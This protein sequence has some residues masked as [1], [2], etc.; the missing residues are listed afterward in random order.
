MS[1]AGVGRATWVRQVQGRLLGT[2]WGRFGCAALGFGLLGLAMAQPAAL[3]ARKVTLTVRP[4]PLSVANPTLDRVGGLR[5]RGGLWIESEDPGFGGLSGLI[6]N[7]G[8]SGPAMLAV[9]DQGSRF[10]ARLVTANGHLQGVEDAA[11]EPLTELGGRPLVGKSYSDAESL[12]RLPDGRILVGFERRHRIWAYGL[13]LTGPAHPLE[14]PHLLAEAPSNGGLESVTSWPDGRV[15]AITESLRLASGN[16]A[17]FLLQGGVWANLEWK[18]SGEGFLPVDASVLPD[19]DL[20]VLERYF[21]ALPPTKVMSRILRVRKDAVRAGAV[22]EGVLMAELASPLVTENFEGLSVLS[23]PG[24]VTHLAVLSDNNFSP[25]QR[26][27]LL[28]FELDGPGL[29][30]SE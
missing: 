4:I 15:L 22:L 6:L 26:T 12:T 17:A 28:W 18:A 20:I 25:L 8:P 14:T 5:Y 9:S 24:G 27:L 13:N 11:L 23:T 19:G 29:T 16:H 1:S 30:P 7:N 3:P 10:S 2:W 21:G